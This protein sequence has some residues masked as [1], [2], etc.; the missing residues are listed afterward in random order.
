MWAPVIA[1]GDEARPSGQAR[2]RV[3]LV[4]I[5]RQGMELRRI[6]AAFA[7]FVGRCVGIGLPEAAGHAG[8]AEATLREGA[9]FERFHDQESGEA[10]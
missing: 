8:V 4:R 1:L 5:A 7:Q 6:D 9:V 3:R 10:V 2:L